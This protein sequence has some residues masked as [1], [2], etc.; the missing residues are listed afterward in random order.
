MLRIGRAAILVLVLT[1]C[2]KDQ[3]LVRPDPPA[4]T[5][6]LD[7]PS[8]RVPEEPG[9]PEPGAPITDTYVVALLGWANAL[10]GVITQDRVT[11]AGERACIQ[12][13]RAAGQVH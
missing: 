6:C 2:G 1:G 13:L 9:R 11:W 4:V 5:A 7:P 10:L 12:R 8:A 3:V